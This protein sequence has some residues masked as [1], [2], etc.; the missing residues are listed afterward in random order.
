[1]IHH[2]WVFDDFEALQ[3]IVTEAKI[4]LDCPRTPSKP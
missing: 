4:M 3:F 2:D 1:L